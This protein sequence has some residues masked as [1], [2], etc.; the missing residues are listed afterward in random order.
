MSFKC[1]SGGTNESA[2]DGA[3]WFSLCGKLGLSLGGEVSTNRTQGWKGGSQ[4]G[5]TND[6]SYNGGP[7]V[8]MELFMMTVPFLQGRLSANGKREGT[9]HSLVHDRVQR[10]DDIKIV[11]VVAS[12]AGFPPWDRIGKCAEIS[13]CRSGM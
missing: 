2:F 5:R 9:A 4:T 13:R 10:L 7:A 11:V 12:K 1:P 6:S 3:R 8:Y